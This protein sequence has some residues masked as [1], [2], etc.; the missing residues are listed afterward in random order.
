MSDDH[1]RQLERR[2]RESGLVQD[3]A[4]LLLERVRVGDLARS[5]LLVLAYRRHAGALLAVREDP[6]FKVSEPALRDL[7]RDLTAEAHRDEVGL[8]LVVG[9]LRDAF[10][11]SDPAHLKAAALG[12]VRTLLESG[13][14][15]ARQFRPDLGAHVLLDLSP[16]AIEAMID[17][18]WT[19]LGREP[20]ISE[21]VDFV[22]RPGAQPGTPDLLSE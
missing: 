16:G 11:I 15:V 10:G 22:G 18:E 12:C 7:Q 3:E 13:E 1:L 14:V 21:V 8:W 2:W 6:D 19:R 5:E 9:T 17:E 4:A 20:N